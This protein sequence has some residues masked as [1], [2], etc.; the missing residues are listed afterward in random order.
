M[1]AIAENSESTAGNDIFVSEFDNPLSE[2][3]RFKI[4][5]NYVIIPRNT[6]YLQVLVNVPSQY[7]KNYG[8]EFLDKLE[9]VQRLIKRQSKLDLYEDRIRVSVESTTLI[10][11]RESGQIRVFV[12]SVQSRYN[13]HNVLTKFQTLEEPADLVSIIETASDPSFLK[14]KLDDSVKYESSRWT[15]VGIISLV[16]NFQTR[17]NFPTTITNFTISKREKRFYDL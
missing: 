9:I 14:S 10:R 15:F 17:K 8:R 6:D 16:L 11:D 3:N 13:T 5:H 12:G 2:R 1:A 4:T 7:L